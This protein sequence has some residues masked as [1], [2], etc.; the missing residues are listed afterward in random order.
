MWWIVLIAI[1]AYVIIKFAIDSNKQADAVIKQGGMRKKYKTLVDN[2]LSGHP[3]A[4]IVQETATF[5][6]IGVSNMGGT[7][8]FFITQTFGT[9]TVEWKIN[10]PLFGKHKLEWTFDEFLDQDK[11]I[12]KIENDVG[13]YTMNIMQN[14]K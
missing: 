5:L 8:S 9:V 6:N 2:L 3:Q 13:K 4:R 12:E 1:V 10:S 14:F 7:T 11:M